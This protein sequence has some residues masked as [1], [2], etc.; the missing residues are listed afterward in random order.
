MPVTIKPFP[1]LVG[2]NSDST[3]HS[4]EQLLKRTAQAWSTP[5]RPYS[6]STGRLEEP[7]NRP[8][9]Q[10]SFD[11]LDCHSMLTPY[12]NGLATASFGHFSK[13]CILSYVQ[14]T[15]GLRF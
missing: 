14:M 3:V 15:S 8:I 6:R 7:E 9:I 2:Y 13:I 10:C 4:A 1:E 12:G 5:S 11:D